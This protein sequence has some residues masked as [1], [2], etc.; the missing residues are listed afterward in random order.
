MNLGL[1][2]C[3]TFL[4]YSSLLKTLQ[5]AQMY[6]MLDYQLY[7]SCKVQRIQTCLIKA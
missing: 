1:L 7:S 6:I 5:V 2:E 3:L 4:E